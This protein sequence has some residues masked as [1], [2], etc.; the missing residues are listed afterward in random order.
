M[1]T[2]QITT[3]QKASPLAFM[4]A[5]YNSDPGKL[6]DTLKATV[7]KDARN[8]Q[9]LMA[10]VIVA[11]QYGLNPL[12]KEIYAFPAKGGGIVPVVGVDGWVNLAN[13][14]PQMDGVDFQWQHDGA[15]LISC[16]AIIH[17]KDRA[18]PVKVTEYLSECRRNTEPWKME[19]RMLR[20]KAFIQGVRVAF[21]LSGIYDE[22]EAER[23]T[24]REV[25]P[26]KAEASKLFASRQPV[27]EQPAL[28]DVPA[29]PLIDQ[30]ASLMRDSGVEW[31]DVNRA[32][33]DNGIAD[34]S[35]AL[36]SDAPDEVLREVVAQF[37]T[38]LQLV[39][40]G[41]Q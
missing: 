1:S 20:H 15:K 11:N 32:L 18:H 16:T 37:T 2:N 31:S 13:S 10:L 4:A 41:A 23:I 14:H 6:Y 40:E 30:A 27:V 39:K 29:V 28:L 9:E 21:G 34:N 36:L 8:D 12:L 22:D 35:Y 3:T 17:R 24:E 25:T 26:A 5:R 7:F 33:M 19:H 38:I